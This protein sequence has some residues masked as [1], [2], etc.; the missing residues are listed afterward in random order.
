[1]EMALSMEMFEPL[2]EVEQ[3]NLD[4]GVAWY[5]WVISPPIAFGIHLYE[6][7]YSNGY[8]STM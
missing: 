8:N 4:G 3:M 6:L 7:G 2:S 5:W 1:M